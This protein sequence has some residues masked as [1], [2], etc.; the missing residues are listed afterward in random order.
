[1]IR[2]P[3]DENGAVVNDVPVARQ[4][5]P[6]RRAQREETESLC[7]CQVKRFTPLVERFIVAI[8]ANKKKVAEICSFPPTKR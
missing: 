6:D 2:A 4:S 8:E 1:L 3:K 7:P 5:R